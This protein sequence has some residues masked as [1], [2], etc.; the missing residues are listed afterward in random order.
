MFLEF[1]GGAAR[2]NPHLRLCGYKQEGPTKRT[3]GDIRAQEGDL[4]LSRIW[5]GGRDGFEDGKVGSMQRKAASFQS[6]KR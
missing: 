1:L 3:E 6:W 4:T 5:N 2:P